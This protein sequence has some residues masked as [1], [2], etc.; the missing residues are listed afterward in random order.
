MSESAIIDNSTVLITGATGFIGSHLADDLIKRG[1][2]VHCAIR[3]TSSLQWLDSS[4]ITFHKTDLSR[5]EPLREALE[6]TEYVFHCAGLTKAKSREEFF[7]ANAEACTNL[8]QA[9]AEYG[10]KIKAIVHLS[11]LAV[12]GPA[13]NHNPV[14]ENTECR[15]LTYYGKSKLAGEEIAKRFSSSLPIIILRPPVVYGPR[16]KDFFSFLKTIS[17]G[18]NPVIGKVRRTLSLIYAHD[19]VEAMVQAASKPAEKDNI[20][21]ITDGNI[22]DWDEI[23]RASM[24]HLKVKART[25]VVPEQ[26]MFPLACLMEAISFFRSGPAFLDRQKIK[27]VCQESWTASSQKFFAAHH[28]QPKYNLDRGLAETINWYKDEHW[29]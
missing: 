21:F 7:F 20:F 11:S 13:T 28:F 8:Y 25:I 10:N 22:Y 23:A 3:K 1:C 27:E 14:D 12:T 6:N 4:R 17:K 15:P 2:K 24:K 5:P 29:L 9:C 19:L 16:E 18:W 26:I